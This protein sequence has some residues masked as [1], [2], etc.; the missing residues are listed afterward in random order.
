MNNR[1]VA[2]TLSGLIFATT[3]FASENPK[4]KATAAE[5]APSDL[6]WV[7]GIR[8]WNYKLQLDRPVSAVSVRLCELRRQ[9]D[10]QWQRTQLA[11][12]DGM[13]HENA[14]IR[15]ID[16]GVFIKE[17]A[18]DYDVSYRIGG[19]HS[20]TKSFKKPDF[21]KTYSQPSVGRFV[22]NCLVLAIEEKT[23]HVAT[24]NE[25]NYVRVIGL[26]VETE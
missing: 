23:P 21:D 7:L 12:G 5:L 19:D 18:S 22:E 26:E 1:V 6:A 8:C 14:D 25:K 9:T 16:L 2:F 4:L 11:P 20:S 15:E 17:K 10:G 24:G 13:K 3:L